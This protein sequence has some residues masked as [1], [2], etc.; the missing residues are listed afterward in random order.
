MDEIKSKFRDLIQKQ[1]NR[2]V[3]IPAMGFSEYFIQNLSNPIETPTTTTKVAKLSSDRRLPDQ[4]ILD[5]TEEIYFQE[6]VNCGEYEL[7]KFETTTLDY[8]TV[9]QAMMVLKQ[10]H[11]VISKKVLQ[12]ILEQ[13]TSCNE[14]FTQINETEKILNDSLVVCRSA[15]S[16][17]NYAKKNLT[18]TSLEILATYKKRE[19]LQGLLETLHTIKKVKSYESQLQ[20]LLNDGN[21]SGAISILLECKNLAENFSQYHCVEALSLKLQ[22]TIMLT[23]LQLD[24]VLNEMTQTFDTKKYSNLQ[25]AYKML[26]KTM[27]AMD[28]LHMNFISAIH[29][30]AF[31]VLRQNTES[32]SDEKQK[33]L[34]EQMC[35]N[36]PVDK[37]ITCLIELCKFFWS[38]L[39]CYYQVTMW[40]QNIQLFTKTDEPNDDYIQQKFKNGQSRIWN[41]IQSKICVYLSSSKLHTLKYEQFIQVLSIVQRLKK[42]G[43]EFCGENSVNLLESM[44]VQSVAFFRRYHA[45]SLEEICLFLDNEAWMPINSFSSVIQLQEFRSVKKSLQ[46]FLN[47]T[48]AGDKSTSTLNNNVNKRIVENGDL[49]NESSSHSQDG[50]SVYGSCGYFYRFSEK[51]SPFDGGFDESMLEEDILAGI[52]DESSC[53]FSEESEE[54]QLESLPNRV[55]VNDSCSSTNTVIVNNSSLNVLR[56]IGR[57]LQMC[58]LLHSISGQIIASMTELIDFYTFVVHDVFGNDLPVPKENLYTNQLNNNLLRISQDVVP[59]VKTWPPPFSMIQMELCNTESSYGLLQRIVGVESCISLVQQFH[60]LRGYMEHLL[61]PN[62]RVALRDFLDTTIEY[63]ND[64]RKPIF[65]C[66]TARVIDLQNVLNAMAKVKWD[67]NHV[68]VEHSAYVDNLN[69]GVQSFQMRLSEVNGIVQVP[70]TAIWDSLAHVLTHTLVEGYANAKKCSA[71][72]RALMQLDFAYFMSILELM[73]NCKFPNHRSYVDAYIKAFYMPKD[74]MEEWIMEQKQRR[75]YSNKQLITLI[76]GTCVNDKKTRQKLLA[77][78][79]NTVICG[80]PS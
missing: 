53:Y 27:I 7:K 16:Y 70:A 5:G 67:I 74:S 1:Q 23:E 66:V 48:E 69:R 32:N 17:L 33:M 65:M 72:G 55:N 73:S 62:D 35:E 4:E 64:L 30:S 10:Q 22:D 59:K 15:R 38:I 14:E 20:Q 49:D 79:E 50:S 61:P 18:T 77:I 42:V 60:Q 6:N 40:H 44:K 11:K 56:C 54:E 52:A 25:E 63:I 41:D 47:A 80:S 12:N 58:R 37:Y 36:V 34:F 13:R 46:R 9:E 78:V 31:T 21:Y 71:G 51:S 68:N 45:A 57:Y 3:K 26:G 19:T 2:N 43:I 75:D 39:V 8:G 24:T 29:T 76:N 28:Q